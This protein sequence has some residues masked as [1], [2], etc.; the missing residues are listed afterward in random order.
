MRALLW[1]CM[2]G[3]LCASAKLQ[4][5]GGRID[6]RFRGVGGDTLGKAGQLAFYS[7]DNRLALSVRYGT[8]E[9]RVSAQLSQSLSTILA[10]AQDFKVLAHKEKRRSK[11]VFSQDSTWIRFHGGWGDYWY[12]VGYNVV[13]FTDALH[14]EVNLNSVLLLTKVCSSSRVG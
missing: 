6:W 13:S 12:R 3:L 7:T 10:S 2:S 1:L 4:W 11:S 8:H 14:G 9:Q 5:H